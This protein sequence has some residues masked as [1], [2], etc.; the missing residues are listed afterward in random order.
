MAEFIATE[1]QTVQANQ[2]V[3]FTNTLSCGKNSIIHRA[4]W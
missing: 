4:D 3:L 2:N 1:V